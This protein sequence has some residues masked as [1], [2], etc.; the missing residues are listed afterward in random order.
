MNDTEYLKKYLN[1][2]KL[3]EGLEKLKQNIPVQY[4]IGDVN[5]YGY[6]IKVNEN[7]LIP[8][9]ETE[10]LVEKIINYSKKSPKII[11]LGTGSGAIAIALK[12]QLNCE[13]DAIDISEKALSLAKENAKLNNVNINFYKSDMLENVKG[14]YDIIVSNPP[15]I[16]YNEKIDEK[17]FNNEPHLALFA[18]EEGLYFYKKILEKAGKHLNKNGFIAF[19][20]GCTQGLK[21]KEIAQKYFEKSKIIIE[22]DYPGKDRYIFIF[23]ENID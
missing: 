15:Y 18:K 1:K 21:I 5:F 3:E 6:Q 10:L 14:K 16:A 4:I 2:D 9:F 8:R 22:K 13:V 7:V 19:E 17:V 20:I 11:D 12:K 23:P